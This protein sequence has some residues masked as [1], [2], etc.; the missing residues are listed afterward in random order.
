MLQNPTYVGNDA[1]IPDDLLE[2]TETSSSVPLVS[3]DLHQGAIM[4]DSSYRLNVELGKK[5]KIHHHS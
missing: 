1:D 2:M 4:D 5:N 3:F